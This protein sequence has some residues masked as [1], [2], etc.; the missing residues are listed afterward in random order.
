MNC[1]YKIVVLCGSTRFKDDFEK[2]ARQIALQEHKIPISLNFYGQDL[3][4]DQLALV[5]DMHYEKM[6]LAD[7]IYVVN[8]NGY[9]GESTKKE[10]EYAKLIN[11]P[12]RY[13]EEIDNGK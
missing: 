2:I 4:Q 12:I 3:T 8:K 11:K 6:K 1:K 13:M 7:E 5:A 9:I 10:I